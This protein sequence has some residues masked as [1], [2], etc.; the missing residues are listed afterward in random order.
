M[1]DGAGG[2]DWLAG[3]AGNDILTGG[4]SADTFAYMVFTEGGDTITDFKQGGDADIIDL[5]GLYA[6][7]LTFENNLT[8]AVDPGVTAH[9]VTWYESGGNTIVQADTT[10][11]AVVDFAI[12]LLGTSL[13]LT[14]TDFVL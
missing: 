10:G 11:D 2:D 14:A 7:V 12:T 1:I 5:A 13:N 6:G 4:T 8:P 9:H 3:G